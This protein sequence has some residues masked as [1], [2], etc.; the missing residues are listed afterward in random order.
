MRIVIIGGGKVGVAIA[1]QLTGE[2]HD[3]TVVDRSQRVTDQISDQLDCMA[4]CGQGTAVS[5]MREAGV[6]QSDL[7]L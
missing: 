1:A 7:M 2:G 3:I 6:D 5:V 4:L